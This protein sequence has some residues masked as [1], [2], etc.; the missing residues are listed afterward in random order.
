MTG[1]YLSA[2]YYQSLLAEAR[3]ESPRLSTETICD[4]SLS[5]SSKSDWKGG[6]GLAILHDA[7]DPL[8][9]SDTRTNRHVLKLSTA[10]R[11]PAE[12]IGPGDHGALPDF[13]ALW[14]RTHTSPANATYGFARRAEELG[15]PVID[16]SASIRRCGNKAF[17]AE[18]FRCNGIPT[19]R[20]LV[21]TQA[22]PMSEIEAELPYPMVVKEPEGSFSTGVYK[23]DI[24]EELEML[25]AALFANS[26]VAVLQ[27]FVPTAFDWRIGLLDGEILFA[28][29]YRM[30]KGHW[31]I[32]KQGNSGETLSGASFAV[33]VG[34]VP[35]EVAKAARSAAATIGR[36]LYG[37]DLKQTEKGVVVI[38]VNDNPDIKRG[39][40]DRADGDAIWLKILSWFSAQT[41]V[42]RLGPRVSHA[43][44][45]LPEARRAS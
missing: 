5:G 41:L 40:E 13:D 23:A 10:N 17:Q 42:A 31:Q 38:E 34:A 28:C 21:V 9:P 16:D 12:I 26:H 22:T 32:L 1:Q 18:R 29:K 19:P 4:A 44:V 37:V 33:P 25:L 39:I 2:S 6:R 7:N 14:I 27:A 30:A 20:T 24:R 3:G 43:T 45:S 15:M 36:G 35:P 8:A 11:M